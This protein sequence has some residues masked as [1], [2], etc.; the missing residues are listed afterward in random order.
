MMRGAASTEHKGLRGF[1]YDGL[2]KLVSD[3]LVEGRGSG[4]RNY[5]VLIRRETESLN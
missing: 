1:M 2:T 3:F 5:I 4:K